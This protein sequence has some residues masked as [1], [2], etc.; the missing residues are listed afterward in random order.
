MAQTTDVGSVYHKLISPP[1]PPPS[2][3]T[4]IWATLAFL[5]IPIWLVVGGL[6]GAVFSRH[7]LGNQEGVIQLLFRPVGDRSD[8]VGSLVG[9]DR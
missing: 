8:R 4:M 3:S 2:S 7:H 1:D 6:I 5:A 9:A